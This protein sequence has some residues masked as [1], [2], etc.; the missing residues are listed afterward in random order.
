MLTLDQRGSGRSR[1]R[2][3]PVEGQRV[4]GGIKTKA[5]R[6][7]AKTQ[8]FLIRFL[9]FFLCDLC[10]FAVKKIVILQGYLKS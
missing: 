3:Q 2:R 8:W 10:G 1:E 4:I 9:K 7:V 5:S 6:K